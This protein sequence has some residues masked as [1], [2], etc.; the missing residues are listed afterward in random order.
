MLGGS[1][2]SSPSIKTWDQLWGQSLATKRS[3]REVK[4]V[5]RVSSYWIDCFDGRWYSI[6]HPEDARKSRNYNGKFPEEIPI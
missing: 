1:S 3:H 6:G 4:P 5:L 2:H